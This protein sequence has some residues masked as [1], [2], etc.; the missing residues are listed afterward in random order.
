MVTLRYIL[1]KAAKLDYLFVVSIWS[2][3]TTRKR[4]WVK[5]DVIA[6]YCCNSIR[7][8]PK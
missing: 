6:T 8:D 3:V 7:N 5:A 2:I 1:Y 4:M